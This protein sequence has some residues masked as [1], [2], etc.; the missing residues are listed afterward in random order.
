[1]KIDGFPFLSCSCDFDENREGKQRKQASMFFG[2]WNWRGRKGLVSVSLSFPS[3]AGS[4]DSKKRKKEVK[5]IRNFC[6]AFVW[7]RAQ[8]FLLYLPKN[9]LQIQLLQSTKNK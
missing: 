9:C 5:I 7:I 8:F 6:W 4:C 1:M 3:S 2:I